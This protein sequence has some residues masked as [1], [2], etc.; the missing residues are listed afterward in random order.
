MYWSCIVFLAYLESG[1]EIV[2]IANSFYFLLFLLGF[3]FVHKI[4]KGEIQ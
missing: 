1:I 3:P 2:S 4:S